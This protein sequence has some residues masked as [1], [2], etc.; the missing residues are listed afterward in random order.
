[1]GLTICGAN[2]WE[3]ALRRK[4]PW[5]KLDVG[6]LVALASALAFAF[7]FFFVPL[8]GHAPPKGRKK[9]PMPMPRLRPRP[10]KNLH[11]AFPNTP[12]SN[13]HHC[14][15]SRRRRRQKLNLEKYFIRKLLRAIVTTFERCR[16]Q[17]L[18][19][20]WKP[21]WAFAWKPA[22]ALTPKRNRAGD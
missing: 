8:R 6:F 15:R 12:C 19:F 9:K 20:A 22:Q 4:G 5:E 3:P 21:A 18:S 14:Q 2:Y 16:V 17:H 7:A 10:L 13:R 1:M 11:P